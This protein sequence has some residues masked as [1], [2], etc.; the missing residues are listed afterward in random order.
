MDIANSKMAYRLP[1]TKEEL[2]YYLENETVFKRTPKITIDIFV[3]NFFPEMNH[4][5]QT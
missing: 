4:G 2:R 5:G 3:K 1:F